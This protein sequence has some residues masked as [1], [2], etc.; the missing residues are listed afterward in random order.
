[1][2]T[3][4]QKLT[5]CSLLFPAMI[6]CCVSGAEITLAPPPKP[7]ASAGSFPAGDEAEN[8]KRAL[9]LVRTMEML[10]A[11]YVDSDKV[12]YGKL[13]DH[14][15]QGMISAL[16]PYS[17]Y[18]TPREFSRQQIR[19]TG[20]LVGI[21]AMAV[22]P[23]GRP[24][25][26]IR[27]LPGTPAERSGLK[28]GD[29]I[30][31]IDGEKI[32]KL[33]LTGALKKLRG[34]PGTTVKLQIRRNE[35]DLQLTLIR[36]KVQ[37]PSV[38]PGS[39]RLIHGKIGYLKLT[40]FTAVT[41]REVEAALKKLHALKAQAIIVDLRYNPGGS[42]DAGVKTA[43]FFL[44]PGKVVFRAKARNKESEKTILSRNS[45][46]CDT[47]TP[48]LLLT[49][50]YTASCSEILAGAL[51]DHKR[52]RLLGVRTFG[53]GTILHVVPVPG[54]GAVRYAAAHYVT[55]GG[56]VIEKKGL[57]PDMEVRLPARDVMLLSAQ[58]LRYPG[59]ILPPHRGAVEDLQLRRAV[60]I[61]THESKNKAVC[62]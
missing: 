27:I 20:E 39:V 53:K 32:H 26:L 11:R 25:T 33:N 6:L 23:E 36:R 24:V 28:P 4:V 41:P 40:S 29:Q 34:L 35:Q 52:A 15:M 58:S 16:D 61:L 10:R 7:V 1:M 13:F 56:R 43:S 49:N 51:Q 59:M 45:A 9:L 60:E 50:E 37:T 57:I 3:T 47:V 5:L 48:L 19:R 22:K 17:D 55:P 38:V 8:Y 44:P 14:A 21:G 62:P 2:V 31:A 12:S 18:E 46:F 30:V 54:G 42:V